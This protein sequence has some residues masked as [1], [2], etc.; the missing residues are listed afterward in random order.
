MPYVFFASA[1]LKAICCAKSAAFSAFAF[2]AAAFS[3]AAFSA[4]AAFV[5]T[6]AAFANVRFFRTGGIYTIQLD[7][8]FLLNNLTQ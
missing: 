1:S 2:S 3:F 7:Y 4:A 5:A 8:F 6:F